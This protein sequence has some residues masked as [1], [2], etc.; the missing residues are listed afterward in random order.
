MRKSSV[1]SVAYLGNSVTA[2]SDS[3]VDLLHRRVTSLW[4][5]QGEP[6]RA[7]L[8]GVGSLA[9]AGLL[10]DLV[11]RHSPRI[12]FVECSLA[13]AGGATPLHMVE[14]S[15]KSILADLQATEIAPVVLH[16]PRTDVDRQVHDSV[17]DIYNRVARAY[18]V[19][20]V[21]IRFLGTHHG[22][23]DGVH[24]SQELSQ[25]MANEIA[26]RLDPTIPIGSLNLE[27]HRASRIRFLPLGSDT[28][29]SRGIRH[30]RYRWTWE[31]TVLENGSSVEFYGQ[32]GQFLG[33]YVIARST[34]G[35]LRIQGARSSVTVQVWDQWC[36][37]PRIQFIHLPAEMTNEPR[38]EV[39]ATDLPIGEQSAQGQ[40]TSAVHAGT[41]AEIMGAALLL[42]GDDE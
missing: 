34:S 29:S 32:T 38:I 6:R 26:A 39:L 17:V 37:K 28:R 1:D 36:T 20:Q 42:A 25:L 21:D 10:E 9:V 3:Y 27:V 19:P 33:V 14:P 12:C 5:L 16:L 8:G 35:V 2:Q 4:G 40:P 11:L 22:F 41:S 18:A 7:G 24:T 15:I 31:T 23:R 30:S 13:D